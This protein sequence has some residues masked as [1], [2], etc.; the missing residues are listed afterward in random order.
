MHVQILLHCTCIGMCSMTHFLFQDCNTEVIW[1]NGSGQGLSGIHGG[2][3]AIGQMNITFWNVPFYFYAEVIKGPNQTFPTL[4]MDVMS[5]CILHKAGLLSDRGKIRQ[6]LQ[7]RRWNAGRHIWRD[8]SW[9]HVHS[10]SEIN[11]R[12]LMDQIWPT[13]C[14]LRTL[15]WILKGS[16]DIIIRWEIERFGNNGIPKPMCN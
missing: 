14:L 12:W 6:W 8:A 1:N 16:S 15:Q 9:R 4:R 10:R 11:S 2:P 5:L 13:G 3:K 7:R